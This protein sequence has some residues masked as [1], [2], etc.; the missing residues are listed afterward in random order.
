MQPERQLSVALAGVG[1]FLV[2]PAAAALMRHP[3][4]P[5][6][7][8][9]VTGTVLGALGVLLGCLVA[10]GH[11]ARAARALGLAVWSLVGV[12]LAAGAV[13]ALIHSPSWGGRALFG[14]SALLPLIGP[15]LTI[16]KREQA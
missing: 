12:G 11:P 3:P 10:A 16:V 15:V 6:G 7:G 8:Q 2:A 5:A 9:L 13:L 14:T 4:T 1:A